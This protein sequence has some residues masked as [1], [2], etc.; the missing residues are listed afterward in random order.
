MLTIGELIERN[1][2]YYSDV[3]AY[4]YGDRRITYAQYAERTRQ[5]ASGLYD[6]GLRRQE[7]VAIL[8]LNCPEYFEV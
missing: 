2:Q 6:L 7:R 5:L 1:A 8:A 4:V 3:E